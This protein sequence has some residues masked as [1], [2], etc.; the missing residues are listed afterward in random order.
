MS[1]AAN[2]KEQLIELHQPHWPGAWQWAFLLGL[3]FALEGVLLLG[4]LRDRWWLVVPLW[5][6]LGHLMHCHL[7][8]FHEAAHKTLI[9]LRL[10]N[11]AAGYLVGT[12]GF[13]SLTLYRTAHHAHHSYIGSPRDVELW[14]FVLPGV[15]RWK[16]RLAAAIELTLGLAF[17][18]FLFLRG[19]LSGDSPVP[20]RH[21]RLLIAAEL[22]AIVLFWAG[23]A[24]MATYW[25]L[26]YF[27]LTLYAIPAIIAGNLQ[28][29]RKY[30]EHMGMLGATPLACTRTVQDRS[31]WGRML[32]FTMLNISLHGVH[33]E[34]AAM[35]Q[36]HMPEAMPLVFTGERDAVSPLPSYWS[37]L[38]EML[39]HLRDPR[40]GSQW[41]PQAS[42]GTR[43]SRPHGADGRAFR[44]LTPS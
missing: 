32:N 17:T 39:P 5:L 1:E 23:V 9:P 44:A 21:D 42:V 6:V 18:P 30:I 24:V 37:A 12:L 13:M 33:H 31:L 29:L 4:V 27:V 7:I 40:V 2:R 25:H 28:S 22:G 11:D 19:Y 20:N 10:L 3:F 8:A 16:R 38:L 26:W 34:Y 14:P 15:A 41:V 43:D 35:P 36:G